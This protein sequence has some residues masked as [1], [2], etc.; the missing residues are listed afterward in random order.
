[1]AQAT[2]VHSTP[3]TNTPVDPTRRRLLT[4]AAGGSIAGF[5]PA[6]ASALPD[7]PIFA[8]IDA[9]RRADTACVAVDGDIPNEIGDR[10]S[11]AISVVMRTRP[12][13]PAGLAALT[14]WA[15]ERADWLSANGTEG[16]DNFCTVSATIDDAARGMS[17]LEPWSPPL[18]ATRGKD[19]APAP[20]GQK[21]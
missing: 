20:I 6:I 4:I 8:A 1:M 12:T 13:T 2:R 5:S 21:A 7:D 3:P 10:W 11:E 16:G 19:E 14:T 18:A 9:F 15:R 17:G